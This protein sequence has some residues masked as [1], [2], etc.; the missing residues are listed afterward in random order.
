[1]VAA[2][3]RPGPDPLA[4]DRVIPGF[5]Q[6]VCSMAD[7]L[8]P[9]A[10]GAL[11]ATIAT[12]LASERSYVQAHKKGG[13]VAYETLRARAQDVAAF[14]QSRDLGRFISAI[15]GERVMPTPLN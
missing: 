1:M 15:V 11:Q 5:E 3:A 14:Y 4:A 12:L 9:R 13:T 10:F 6:H 2:F 8:P 7:L